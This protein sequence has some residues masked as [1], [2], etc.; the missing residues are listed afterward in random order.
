MANALSFFRILI[1]LPVVGAILTD[2][3]TLAL[4]LFVLGSISDLIDGKVARERGEEGSLGK[5][6]DPFADKVLV[7]SALIA[8]VDAGYLHSLPVILLTIR[9]LAISF[10]RSIAVGQGI[11]IQASAMGKAKTFFENSAVI[12]FLAG[13]Q[14]SNL[15]LWSSVALAYIS[16]YDYIK[17]YIRSVSGLNYH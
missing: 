10:L 13:F 17:T 11:V 15:L 14:A 6:L 8:L 4:I 16:L 9:E 12:A 5:L 7:I 2:Q 1:A 3:I